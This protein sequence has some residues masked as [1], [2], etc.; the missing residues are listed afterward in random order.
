M[1]VGGGYTPNLS[2][3]G[4][5]PREMMTNYL[6]S[7]SGCKDLFGIWREGLDCDISSSAFM[8][9]SSTIII[10]VVSPSPLFIL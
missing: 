9:R 1:L 2:A 4:Y 5:L 6:P 8:G 3:T 10:V 7:E